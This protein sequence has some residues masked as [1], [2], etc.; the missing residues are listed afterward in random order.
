MSLSQC[1]VTAV[2]RYP[3]SVVEAKG[4]PFAPTSESNVIVAALACVAAA[5]ASGIAAMVETSSL[6]FLE[7]LR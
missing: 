5:I 3:A 7:T 6:F 1:V 2:T 4:S